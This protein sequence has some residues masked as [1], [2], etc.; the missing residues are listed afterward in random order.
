MRKYVSGEALPGA[1]LSDAEL[2]TYIRNHASTIWHPVGT[3]KMGLDRQAVVDPHLRVHGIAGLRI[4]DASIMPTIVS[5]NP[6][7]A[8][9]MIGE[10][11]SDL[12]RGVAT[13]AQNDATTQERQLVPALS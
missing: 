2:T 1:E 6:N 3:C 12:I 8:T 4:A 10:R 5:A 11:A 9:I 7:A 13:S